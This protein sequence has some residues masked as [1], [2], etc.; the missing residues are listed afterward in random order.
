[1]GVSRTFLT[2]PVLH[3][4]RRSAPFRRRRVLRI[5]FLIFSALALAGVRFLIRRRRV[6]DAGA[7]QLEPVSSDWLAQARGRHEHTP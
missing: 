2:E 3:R 5:A 1:M 6:K 4:S 7:P